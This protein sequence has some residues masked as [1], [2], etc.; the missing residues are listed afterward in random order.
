V[1]AAR[2]SDVVVAVVGITAQ[3]EGEESE[4]SDPGFFGGDRTDI[5][6]PEPQEQLLQAL[7]ATGKPLVVV[8]TNGSAVAVNWANEHAVAIL[9]AWYPGEE[10][11]AAVGSVL[12]GEYNPAGRLP[13]T[14][15]K[16]V[17]QLPPF[18]DY[19]M[20]NRTYRY[21]GEPV[22]FPFGFGLSYSTFA[23]SD[24]GISDVDPT[25]TNNVAEVTKAGSSSLVQVS[26]SA[27][28]YVRAKIS[29]TSSVAGDEVAEL[30]ISHPGVDGAPIRALAGFKRV[31]LAAGEFQVVSFA[32]GSRELS[33][34]DAN[35]QR[36]VPAGAVELWIGS[37]QPNGRGANGVGLKFM[38]SG[39]SNLAN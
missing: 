18:T 39:S 25:G 35:G 26:G 16:S 4:N 12:S 20:A 32:L 33:I 37:S 22:L 38:I 6:L 17:A 13:V 9:D 34:V 14:F 31:H 36:V 28:V 19:S 23:Y 30:Y 5:R 3:L 10:G 27:P 7:A 21:L 11:G 8:L 1:E 15:Y 24:V 2:K 29:N